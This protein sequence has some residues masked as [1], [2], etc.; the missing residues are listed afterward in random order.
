MEERKQMIDNEF[1]RDEQSYAVIG[2]AMAVHAELG[3]GFLEAVYQEALAIEFQAR[4]I[5]FE[6]EIE[7]PI[8]YRGIRLKTFFKAD[9]VCFDAL[10]VELK[11]LRQISGVEE[12]QVIN[13]L[14][15]SRHQK[16]LLL[17]FGTKS[18]QQKRFVL[19]R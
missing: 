5:P 10:I 15:A 14:K 19:Q 12:A 13:Y 9:C 3:S 6:R 18:L 17:N 2:A 7:F 11:A 1:D 4:E 16:A 8:T